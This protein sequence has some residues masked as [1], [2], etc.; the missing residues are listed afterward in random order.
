MNN[1]RVSIECLSPTAAEQIVRLGENAFDKPLSEAIDIPKLSEKWSRYAKFLIVKNEE[2]LAALIVYYENRLEKFLYITHFVV[3]PNYRHMG[4]GH[5]ALK[6][7]LQSSDDGYE[8]IRLEVRK[9]NMNAQKFYK[10]EG[11]VI[12]EEK[13]NSYLLV[14][15][16]EAHD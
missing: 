14:R 2:E 10:K 16:I 4:L 3:M 13:E 1:L 9:D 11:F 7:L 5:Y 8:Q 12:Q 6:C 15:N